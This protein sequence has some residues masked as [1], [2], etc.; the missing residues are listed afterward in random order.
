MEYIHEDLS[1]ENIIPA[2]AILR[3][4][5]SDEKA[6]EIMEKIA[7]GIT[8]LF[9]FPDPSR[10]HENIRIS[11]E[12]SK[13]QPFNGVDEAGNPAPGIFLVCELDKPT[14]DILFAFGYITS[15]QF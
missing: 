9:E 8:C 2:G 6:A 10:M 13:A 4:I 7:I 3:C 14:F 11:A 15:Q 1:Q 12:I 5:E